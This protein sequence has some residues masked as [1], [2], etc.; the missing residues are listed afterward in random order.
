MALPKK[1]ELR[2]TVVGDHV[3]PAAISYAHAERAAVD[4]RTA[5]QDLRYGIH[6]LPQGIHYKCLALV[7]KLGLSFAAFDMIVTPDDRY[8]FLE[9]NPNGQW[10]WIER[11]TGFLINEMLVDLLV[12]GEAAR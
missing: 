11:A 6:Q 2:I 3:F 10:Q 4:W 7:H 5:Y 1:V 9:L 12:G 8:V